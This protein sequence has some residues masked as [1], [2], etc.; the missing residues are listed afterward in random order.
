LVIFRI[1]LGIAAF[2][3]MRRLLLFIITIASQSVLAREPMPN[4]SAFE[5]QIVRGS[6]VLAR[7]G[8][9]YREAIVLNRVGTNAV[10][11][12]FLE[13]TDHAECAGVRQNSGDGE[14][15]YMPYVTQREIRRGVPFVDE[16]VYRSGDVVKARCGFM[17]YDAKVSRIVQGDLVDVVFDDESIQEV[18]G[19]QFRDVDATIVP[20]PHF[21]TGAAQAINEA[22]WDSKMNSAWSAPSKLAQLFEQRTAL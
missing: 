8:A 17:D 16:R 11:V 22:V 21:A 2:R 10:S 6:Q 12:R 18:C 1:R 5:A 7:C 3:G 19:G 9:S 20:D 15:A 14:L 13:A 4:P